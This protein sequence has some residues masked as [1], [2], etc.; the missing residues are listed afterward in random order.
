MDILHELEEYYDDLEWKSE[1]PEENDD[2]LLFLDD[3]PY[4]EYQPVDLSQASETLKFLVGRMQP[5]YDLEALDIDPKGIPEFLEKLMETNSGGT[6]EQYKQLKEFAESQLGY[7]V[8]EEQMGY[9]EHGKSNSYHRRIVVDSN[10]NISNKIRVLSHE[11]GHVILHGDPEAK[12]KSPPIEEVEAESVAMI[13]SDAFGIEADCCSELYIAFWM[14]KTF[15]FDSPEHL[16]T[17]VE[18]DV[19]RACMRIQYGLAM[20][21]EEEEDD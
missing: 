6:P 1:L 11:I 20:G 19:E 21:M 7:K 5:F 15:I 2:D 14:K 13:M 17:T 12:Q 16:L 4:E 8:E 3:E 9:G 18:G 10:L